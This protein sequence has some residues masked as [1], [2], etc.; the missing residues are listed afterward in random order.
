MYILK[1]YIFTGVLVKYYLIIYS[2]TYILSFVG[3]NI[4]YATIKRY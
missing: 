1:C 3:D 2:Q 4:V